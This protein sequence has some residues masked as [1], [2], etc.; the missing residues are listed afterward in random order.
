MSFGSGGFGSGGGFGSTNNNS[1]SSFGGFGGFGSGNTANTNT[2][3]GFSFGSNNQPSSG[4][5]LFGAANNTTSSGF[6]SGGFGGNSSGFGSAAKPG[7]FG[8]TNAST[9]GGSLFGSTATA[10]ASGTGFGGFG[11][12]TSTTSAFGGANTGGGLFGQQ[13]KPATGFGSTPSGGGLFG[14]GTGTSTST[15]AF[16]AAASS[17]LGNT[18][19]NNNGTA[20]TP[21]SAYTEKDNAAN[22]NAHYQ[23][24]TFQSPYQGLS[25]EELRMQDYAQGRRYGNPNGQAGAF[26]TSTGFGGF[27]SS[28]N[29][30]T[31][32]FGANNNNSASGGMFGSG[33]TNTTSGF[34][35]T[36][37]NTSGGFG[38]S[39]AGG[40][41]FGAK[42]AGAGGLFGSAASSQPASGGLFGTAGSTPSTGFGSNT[43]SA[44]GSNTSSGGGLFGANNQTQNKPAFGGGFGSTGTGSAFGG[45]TGSGFGQQNNTS[46]GSNLFG[47]ASNTNTSSPFGAANNQ[48]AQNTSSPFGG[49]GQNN[50]TQPQNQPQGGGLFG[51]GFGANNN[52]QQ[53]NK[54]LFGGSTT[55]TGGGLFGANNQQQNQPAAGG[56]FGANNN[57]QQNQAG[58][59]FGNKPAGTT[60]GLFGSGSGPN[61][62]TGSNLFGGLGQN[63][64]PAQNQGGG[65]F[66]G[67]ANNNQQLQ[68]QNKPLFGSSTGSTGGGLF[69]GSTFGQSN[70]NN[71]PGG[72][73]GSFFGGNTQQNQPQQSTLGGSLF[74]NSTAQQST[75][76]APSLTASLKDNPYGHDNL[77]ASLTSPA[78]SVGPLATPL[79]SSQKNKKSAILPQHRINPAASSRLI[80]PQRRMTG[81]GFSTFGTPGTALSNGSPSLG[82]SLVGGGNFSKSLA[83]SFSTSTLRNPINTEDSI[84]SPG[85]FNPAKRPSYATT[86]S[87]KKLNINRS[88]NVRPSLFGDDTNSSPAS[89]KKRVSFDA[90][91]TLSNGHI[92]G[93][94]GALV[95][96]ERESATPSAEEQGFLRSS[97]NADTSKNVFTNGDKP[98]VE[99]VKG[100]ELTLTNKNGSPSSA[101]RE[102]ASELGRKAARAELVAGDYWSEP[103]VEQLKKMSKQELKSVPNFRVGRVAVGEIQFEKPVDLSGVDLD[104]LFSTT[105]CLKPRNATVY[106]TKTTTPPVGKGLN[107]TSLI[108]LENSW[109]RAS[110]D[111]TRSERFAKHVK[112]LQIVDDTEFVDYN[113]STGTW[114]FRVYHFTTYGLDYDEDDD[115]DS[116]PLDQP[117]ALASPTPGA[118]NSPLAPLSTLSRLSGVDNSL[119]SPAESSPDDTFEF[120]RGKASTRSVPGSF[121][122]EAPYYEDDHM[123]YGQDDTIN[124]TQSFLD[125][126]SVGPYEDGSDMDAA[127]YRSGSDSEPE[128]N[129][130]GS[131][132]VPDRTTEP[133]PT[134][135]SVF[136][137]TGM[138]KSIL[139]Q[140][141]PFRNSLGTPTKQHFD[142]EGDW[143]AQLQRTISPKKQDRQ[144]L[145][146]NQSNVLKVFDDKDEVTPKASKTAAPSE[147][148]ANHIDLM[149]SLF[150]AS[151]ARKTGSIGPGQKRSGLEWPY[152][153]TP[154]TGDDLGEM[155]ERDK[156]FHDSFKPRWTLDGGFTYTV[157]GSAPRM[158]GNFF[159]NFGRSLVGQQKD[160][161]FAKFATPEDIWSPTMEAQALPNNTEIIDDPPRAKT[162]EMEFLPLAGLVDTGTSA[163]KYEQQVWKLASILFDDISNA[164][165]DLPA[166]VNPP[167]VRA[168]EELIRTEILGDFWKAIVLPEAER[169]ARLAKSPEERAIAYLSANCV[170]EA[171]EAL[172]EGRN[173][174][175]ATLVSQIGGPKSSREA[176]GAQ[177]EQWRAQA[178]WSEISA[179][180]RAIYTLLS[181]E[182][183]VVE[184][185]DGP[186]ID[187]AV[188]IKISQQFGLDWRQAFGLRLWYAKETLT[189]ESSIY[190]TVRRFQ[191]ELSTGDEQVR[192][193]PWFVREGVDMGWQDP[194]PQER[195]DLLWGLLKLYKAHSSRTP[196]SVTGIFTP[197]NAT[198][199]PLNARLSWQ[200]LTLLRAKNILPREVA[201]PNWKASGDE[202]FN[203]LEITEISDHLNQTF[204]LPLLT[205]EHWTHAAWVLIHLTDDTVRAEALK[206]LL[207][208]HASRITGADETNSGYSTAVASNEPSVFELLTNSLKIPRPWIFTALAQHARAVLHDPY[209]EVRYLLR[210]GSL[211]AAHAVLTSTVAP[212]A[213]ISNTADELDALRGLLAMFVEHP[214]HGSIPTADWKRGG[215]VYADY[216]ELLEDSN[217][218]A[219]N[220]TAP[221]AGPGATA[222]LERERAKTVPR[223]AAALASLAPELGNK[224][225]VER[226]ALKEIA[227]RLLKGFGG[228]RSAAGAKS[229]GVGAA[230]ALQAQLKELRGMG[231]TE[232]IGLR[233]GRAEGL[234]YYRA[235]VGGV[236]V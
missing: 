228:P 139:K 13:N 111:E 227:G 66:G 201:N 210:A 83:K 75:N 216:L 173:F 26:G 168:S 130:V 222:F 221:S 194:K 58:G 67:A 160:V 34:G 23:T 205:A 104:R 175:L 86:G 171:C 164:T 94:N 50:Q 147:T 27:G 146:D 32:A 78:Q 35:S 85:A 126:R 22:Q 10:P 131:F 202:V 209:L 53:Q 217:I 197:E 24:I 176:M 39:P 107:V 54:P 57:Q 125:E 235:V 101:A 211:V 12:N 234:G 109:P 70:N 183:A 28:N 102:V 137:A 51:S 154:K 9:T 162:L 87:M 181:G 21:F 46:T 142:F 99:Q 182:C 193:V 96:T 124:S 143:A 103:P 215:Q 6:G 206:S 159:N 195:E 230:A 61:T 127:S 72:L 190:Q 177:I 200:L 166:C 212:A 117:P 93:A 56:L 64:N 17:A 226:A 11:N 145:R 158:E 16:G 106:P 203:K 7:G 116:M 114:K 223:L 122:T 170:P 112:R 207:S 140:S 47:G 69:G 155:D 199:N 187:R 5:G 123:A 43:G 8:T 115:I 42:P 192:P 119:V 92:D 138:P 77:F 15:P 174:R 95:P 231:V 49:F 161:R 225:L 219:S 218:A 141:Q 40:G 136:D 20:A 178:V 167:D 224:E 134:K 157:P 68:Q 37:N 198:G 55:G 232:E 163:G 191:D 89:Q 25:L 165:F 120:K 62:N 41:L 151:T 149:S 180:I 188:E 48:P 3:G 100:N 220:A 97:K 73:G 82:G 105:I 30:T 18:P 156:A 71:A 129:M 172:V 80:T 179:P 38:S 213:V 33:N 59:L 84:L 144:A 132:P 184:E 81:L 233:V 1:G 36:P 113:P 45:S 169:Q 44:F 91:T 148:I 19:T 76:Q 29:S 185:T 74:G 214:G 118:R 204:A 88:L 14:G 153:K 60:G 90:S 152:Q 31:S 196:S 186:E 135:N 2:G 79:S 4:G 65:L 63:Q 121:D 236:R 150:G 128:Q 133:T 110:K 189:P 208:F 98:E 108:T 229:K 52:Q